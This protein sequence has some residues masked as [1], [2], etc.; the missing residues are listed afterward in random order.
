MAVVDPNSQTDRQWELL[1]RAKAAAPGPGDEFNVSTVFPGRKD[2]ELARLEMVE[3]AEFRLER[4]GWEWFAVRRGLALD[5]N[6]GAEKKV[7]INVNPEHSAGNVQNP[8]GRAK[9][10]RHR[11]AQ[12][13]GSFIEVKNVFAA[14][15]DGV[16]Q[17]KR[18]EVY[19]LR[20]LRR[21][22][23]RRKIDAHVYAVERVFSIGPRADVPD[24][25]DEFKIPV[26]ALRRSV[27]V[28]TKALAKHFSKVKDPALERVKMFEPD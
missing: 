18:F 19:G 5:K 25:A 14:P 4:R 13:P 26:S 2:R 9:A 6:D 1:E 11:N 22:L 21:A 20:F 17:L 8:G 27:K 12:S 10:A 24:I 15:I 28:C 16:P 7:G 3:S 23:K